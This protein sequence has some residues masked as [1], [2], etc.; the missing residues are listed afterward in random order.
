V[1]DVN[2]DGNADIVTTGSVLLGNGDGTSWAPI[3]Y[4]V[5]SN[6]DSVAAGDFDGI[7]DLAVSNDGSNTV[8]VVLGN[9]KG[10]F[11]AAIN[12]SVGVDP[13]SVA[14]RLLNLEGVS[15]GPMA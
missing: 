8:R 12:Y 15:P 13:Y 4:A 10:T 14:D 3:Y 5:G 1:A 11:R 2:G 6:P 9:G 7:L